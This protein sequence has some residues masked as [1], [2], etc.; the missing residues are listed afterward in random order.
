LAYGAGQ[1]A[2]ALPITPGGLGAVEG[3]ITIALVAFGGAHLA[4]VDAVLLYRLISFWLVLAVGWSLWGELAF[5]VRRGKWGRETMFS[6][7]HP[8]SPDRRSEHGPSAALD[9][10]SAA[11]S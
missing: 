5:E 6:S 3:S 10:T 2:A 4:T 11:G 7:A 1:L 8:V 9:Q